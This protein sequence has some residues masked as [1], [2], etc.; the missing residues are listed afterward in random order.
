MRRLLSAATLAVAIS[1]CSDAAAPFDP[2]LLFGKYTLGSI[3]GQLVPTQV[4]TGSQGCSSRFTYGN[5]TLTDGAFLLDLDGTWGIC[6]GAYLGGVSA[7]QG[8]I[9]IGGG[10]QVTDRTLLLRSVDW[11]SAAGV[12]ISVEGVGSGSEVQLTFAPGV[13]SVAEVTKLVF[14]RH[15]LP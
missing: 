14:I 1:A 13:M 5:L 4:A 7:V 10:L 15:A 3:N 8:I 6:P 9:S 2:Q 11:S 12:P